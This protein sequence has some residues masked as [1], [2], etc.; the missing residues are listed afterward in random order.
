M[1]YRIKALLKLLSLIAILS[2]PFLSYSQRNRNERATKYFINAKLKN[3]RSPSSMF[4]NHQNLSE[5]RGAL[6]TKLDSN[7]TAYFNGTNFDPASRTEINYFN[8]NQ[9]H[10]KTIMLNEGDTTFKSIYTYTNN[11]IT[12]NYYDYYTNGSSNSSN[13]YSYKYDVNG[14]L[15]E[16]LRYEY[17]STTN[18]EYKTTWTYQNNLLSLETYYEFSNNTWF[19]MYKTELL[20][21]GNK[22]STI[23]FYEKDTSNSSWMYNYKIELEYNGNGILTRGTGYDINPTTSLSTQ[24]FKEE[25]NIN[26]KNHLTQIQSFEWNGVS[27][28]PYDQEI[29]TYDNN[30]NLISDEYSDWDED[31]NKYIIEFKTK[32]VYDNTKTTSDVAFPARVYSPYDQAIYYEFLIPYPEE[33]SSTNRLTRDTLYSYDYNTKKILPES[34]SQYYYS[35]FTTSIKNTT[36]TTS[37]E[38][39]PNPSSGNINIQISYPYNATLKLY[40]ELGILVYSQKLSSSNID[41]N[42]LSKGLYIVTLESEK[43][44]STQKLVVQ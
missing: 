16:E 17:N 11:Q 4:V 38:V 31:F 22:L 18:P 1:K 24:D 43:G 37:L 35:D 40:N 26:S 20:Y 12:D 14:K 33:G 28:D 10:F 19:E 6:N 30:E 27:W 39:F 23:K 29:L 7:T 2:Q 41:I 15:I 9:N 36:S 3:H 21:T 44:L 13:R 32:Y 5:R 42:N 34:T 8:S 25:Y